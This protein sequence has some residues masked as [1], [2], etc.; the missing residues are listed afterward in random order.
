MANIKSQKKR[1]ITNAK[2]QAANQ[3]QKTEV[4]G[5]IK[6]VL[7]AVEAKDAEGAK[8]AFDQ[9]NSVL[10]KAVSSHLKKGNYAARQKSRL[11]K[12]VNSISE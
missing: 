1:A 11:A 7:A 8:K 2:R 3:G 6:N 10:D 12:A 4:K 5:A 9:A